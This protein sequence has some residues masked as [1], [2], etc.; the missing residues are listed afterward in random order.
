MI[1]YGD[2]DEYMKKLRALGNKFIDNFKRF[3]INDENILNCNPK[4]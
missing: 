3:N 1:S 4:I 2:I